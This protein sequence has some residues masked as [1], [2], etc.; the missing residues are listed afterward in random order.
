MPKIT[1]SEKPKTNF[2]NAPTKCIRFV[3]DYSKSYQ[4][5]DAGHQ[6]IGLTLN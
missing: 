4:V 6:K 5:V 3:L 2:K 1:P